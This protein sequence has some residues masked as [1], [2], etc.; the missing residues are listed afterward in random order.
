MIKIPLSSWSA[1]FTAALVG[2]GGTLALVI[3]AA[4]AVGATS[5][6]LASWVTAIC[7]AIAVGAALLS[8]LFRMPIVTAWSAAGLALVGATTG[9]SID[10]AVG[11]FLVA[12][13]LL[14]VT[15]LF[16]PLTRL[17]G[18][19]PKGIAAGMLAGILINFPLAATKASIVD[20]L[21]AV[22][23]IIVFFVARTT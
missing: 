16:K 6:Q 23:V 10:Q 1:A 20:P 3:A 11:A 5:S 7:L 9:F 12:A 14:V 22:P 13:V 2:A 8:T 21:L 17:V 4:Q 19:I 15:G 18:L